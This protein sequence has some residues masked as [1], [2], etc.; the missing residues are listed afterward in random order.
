[1][2]LWSIVLY[3]ILGIAAAFLLY[4]IGIVILLSLG[5]RNKFEEADKDIEKMP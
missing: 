4:L 1:M 5:L 2:S 3:G